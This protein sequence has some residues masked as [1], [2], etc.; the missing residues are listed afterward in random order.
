ML[1]EVFHV[2][3]AEGGWEVVV[4]V[5][6]GWGGGGGGGCGKSFGETGECGAGVA[7]QELSE[8]RCCGHVEGAGSV[9]LLWLLLLARR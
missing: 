9:L 2:G 3:K 5:V 1:N 4:V 8:Q 7:W 6:V